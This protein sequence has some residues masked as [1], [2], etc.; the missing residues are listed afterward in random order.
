MLRGESE[1]VLKGIAAPESDPTWSELQ[2]NRR[3]LGEHGKYL[4]FV[5]GTLRRIKEKKEYKKFVEGSRQK[6]TFLLRI[7]LVPVRLH[8]INVVFLIGLQNLV[9]EGQ[10]AGQMIP[11]L[12]AGNFAG[13]SS[14]L[15]ARVVREAEGD[16]EKL[17]LEFR[18]A[19]DMRSFVL[20]AGDNF[21]DVL[22]VVEKQEGEVATIEAKEAQAVMESP[23][24]KGTSS[25]TACMAEI[26]ELYRRAE[27]RAKVRVT[28]TGRS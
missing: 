6:D 22:L 16:K 9:V 2:P 20:S 10:N 4:E 15:P 5:S 8:E 23:D 12:W 24:I 7:E 26:R 27:V 1:S 19:G 11:L 3:S 18:V 14:Y 13:F 21:T 17:V 25:R 28:E